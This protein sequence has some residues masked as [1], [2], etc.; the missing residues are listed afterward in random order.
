MRQKLDTLGLSSVFRRNHMADLASERKEM[1]TFRKNVLFLLAYFVAVA[2][3]LWFD[4]IASET[5]S[6]VAGLLIP[7][8]GFA[9]ML[10]ANARGFSSMQHWGARLAARGVTV[11]VFGVLLLLA[12]NIYSWQVVRLLGFNVDQVLLPTRVWT[13]FRKLPPL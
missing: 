3:Y 11:V 6:D 5:V 8:I 10:W 1:S 2:G 9:G 7:L 4:P 13:T 12:T